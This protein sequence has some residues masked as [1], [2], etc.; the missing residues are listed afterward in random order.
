MKGRLFNGK[1]QNVFYDKKYIYR[2]GL[3]FLENTLDLII[4]NEYK[5][6]LTL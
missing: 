5:H 4:T 1:N 3:I 2:I 6:L